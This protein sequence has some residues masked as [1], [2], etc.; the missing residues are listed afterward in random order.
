MTISLTLRQQELLRFIIGFKEVH[1]RQPTF[2][3]MRRGLSLSNK[4]HV[5]QLIAQ[6]ELRGAI[7][8]YRLNERRAV[9]EVIS[10]LAIPRAPDGA[11][12]RA[13]RG[14]WQAAA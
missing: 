12:L 9:I 5:R 8:R 13:V 14:P 2:E 11:P 4:S 3:E 7:R 1:C 6:L 10:D